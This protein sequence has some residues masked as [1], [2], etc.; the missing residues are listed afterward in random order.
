VEYACCLEGGGKECV[1]N[2]GGKPLKKTT[3]RWSYRYRL[4][5]TKVG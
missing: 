1:Q 3:L 5:A 2:F 4:W